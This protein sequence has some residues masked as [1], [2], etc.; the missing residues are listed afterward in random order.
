MPDQKQVTPQM[1]SSGE[2][3][4][5]AAV[6]IDHPAPDRREDAVG[7]E[8]A[9]GE[10]PSFTDWPVS[11]ARSGKRIAMTSE[12]LLLSNIETIQTIRSV[13]AM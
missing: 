13:G 1:T 6:T 4:M 5:R 12:M 10:K 7:D 11:A 9:G 3:S 8:Q 2:R